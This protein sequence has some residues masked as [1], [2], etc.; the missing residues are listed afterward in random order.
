[1]GFGLLFL[2]YFFMLFIPLGE[3]NLFLNLAPIGCIIM[4]FALQKLIKYCQ[5]CYTFKWART[6][7]AFL[8]ASTLTSFVLGV[9]TANPLTVSITPYVEILSAILLSTYSILLF[10]GIFKLSAEVELPKLSARAR[11]MITVALVYGLLAL[12]SG[13]MQILFSNATNLATT[14]LALLHYTDFASYI[15][16]HIFLF[17]TLALLF[18]CYIRIC[19]EGDEDMMPKDKREKKTK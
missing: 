10:I 8:L 6:V 16:E 15:L 3:L 17:L 19:L 2:G 13:I 5:S 1:M 18:T 7:L 14:T 4:F 9:F 11:R 12:V